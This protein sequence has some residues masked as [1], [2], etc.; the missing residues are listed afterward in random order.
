MR[1]LLVCSVPWVSVYDG[2]D[3]EGGGTRWRWR[4]MR[5]RGTEIETERRATDVLEKNVARSSVN[6]LL[7]DFH[8]IPICRFVSHLS[9]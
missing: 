8:F 5:K 7:S 2:D 6:L 3:S 1:S 4:G 9:E